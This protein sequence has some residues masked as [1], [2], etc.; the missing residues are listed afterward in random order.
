[1]VLWNIKETQS[2]LK[3]KADAD[4]YAELKQIIETYTGID[5]DQLDVMSLL[6]G[7][8][9]DFDLSTLDLSTVMQHITKEE[10]RL[11]TLIA[12]MAASPYGLVKLFSIPVESEARPCLTS[13]GNPTFII[14][15][16]S[17]IFLL[18]N[19]TLMVA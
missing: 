2:N 16:Y 3:I 19:F 5:L 17:D 1:M 8:L 14:K 7:L 9:G 12:A 10:K 11:T 6:G 18:I 15:K 13:A 4:D